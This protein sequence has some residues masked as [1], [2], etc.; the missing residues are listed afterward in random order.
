MAGGTTSCGDKMLN[1]RWEGENLLQKQ[2]RNPRGCFSKHVTAAMA[3]GVVLWGEWKHKRDGVV[4]SCW[5]GLNAHNNLLKVVAG[6]LFCK[7]LLQLSHFR[8]VSGCNILLLD[9]PQEIEEM[10]Q[11]NTHLGKAEKLGWKKSPRP[12]VKNV[13][14]PKWYSLCTPKCAEEVDT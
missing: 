14:S 9:I 4:L 7:D 6:I 10:C 5:T 2:C 11:N 3:F 8:S 12:R 1:N 13:S